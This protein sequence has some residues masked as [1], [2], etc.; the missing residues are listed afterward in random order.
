MQATP[1]LLAGGERLL[2]VAEVARICSTTA[3]SVRSWISSGTL[4]SLLISRR[5]RRVRASVL[6]AFIA[7][8]E[9]ARS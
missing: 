7:G 6:A 2:T 3:R 1:D 8:K 4:P 9:A 5:C